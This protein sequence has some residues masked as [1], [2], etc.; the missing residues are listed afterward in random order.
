MD[1][2]KFSKKHILVATIGFFV[3]FF[4]GL[5]VALPEPGVL[6]EIA[7]LFGFII[8]LLYLIFSQ[9]IT[10]YILGGVNAIIIF[11]IMVMI[12]PAISSIFFGR[13]FYR[14]RQNKFRLAIG[15]TFG[16]FIVTSLFSILLLLIFTGR[17]VD[18]IVRIFFAIVISIILFFPP[19]DPRSICSAVKVISSTN[20]ITNCVSCYFDLKLLSWYGDLQ[21]HC[22]GE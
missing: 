6:Q 8:Y 17:Y 16:S 15:A 22:G 21:H 9:S 2:I 4:M 20:I 5:A 3:G 11:V 7:L 18:P 19:G 14:K 13:L 12:F 1:R 10:V